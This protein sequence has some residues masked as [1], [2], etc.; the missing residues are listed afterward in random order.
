MRQEIKHYQGK[1]ITKDIII[2]LN[3]ISIKK[4]NEGI[5]TTM[6]E[7]I[8]TL[9]ELCLWHNTSINEENV[10][11]GEDF[12]IIYANRIRN[13]EILEWVALNTG[14][15]KLTQTIEM[16]N[17]LK[18]ILLLSKDKRIKANMKH[19][20]S[21]PFYQLLLSRNYFD[22]ICDYPQIDFAELPNGKKTIKEILKKYKTLSNYLK[23]N[24]SEFLELE[25]Y[26]SHEAE[27]KIT[28]K[29]IKKYQK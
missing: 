28:D 9:E 22:E 8:D 29:F 23:S 21:Y 15:N 16:F 10:I 24:T 12:Y 2:K 14:K 1:E 26:I 18:K 6:Y 4:Y 13:I 5:Y 25:N 3:Q 20:T 17:E 7:Q 19:T 27:F 11:L